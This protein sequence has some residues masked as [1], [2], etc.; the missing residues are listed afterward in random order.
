MR[1]TK[2]ISDEDCAKIFRQY[3]THRERA[4]AT[5]YTVNTC[6]VKANDLRKRGYGVPHALDPR[7]LEFVDVSDYA[8]A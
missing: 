6:V 8:P 1:I 7:R 2:F 5:G 4:A 3:L